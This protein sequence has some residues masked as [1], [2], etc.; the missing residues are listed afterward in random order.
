VR[1][2][3]ILP[4]AI[5]LEFYFKVLPLASMTRNAVK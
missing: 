1:V 2:G 3:Y 4:V 5:S